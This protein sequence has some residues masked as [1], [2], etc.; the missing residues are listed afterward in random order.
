MSGPVPS[1]LVL[2]SDLARSAPGTKVRFLGCVDE[3][4]VQTATLRLKH[5]FPVSRPPVVANLDIEHVLDRI[6]HHDIEV[7]T[8]LNVIGYVER[9][10]EAAGVFVQAIA[11]WDAGNVDLDA[12]EKA[13]EKRNEAA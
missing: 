1:N 10:Q 11:V 6:K 9:R 5:H 13:V 8:W 12:Y 4:I 3:Y 7:G 2:L